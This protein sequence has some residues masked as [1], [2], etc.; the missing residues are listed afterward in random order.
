MCDHNQPGS[1]ADRFE[2]VA[3]IELVV[4]ANVDPFQDDA[5]AF[6]EEVPGNDVRVVLHDAEDDFISGLQVPRRPCV[7]HEVD[8]LGR[9][10][11]EQDLVTVAGAQKSP[12][13]RADAFV[14]FRCEVGQMVQPSVHIGVLVRVGMGYCVD[15]RLLFFAD[16]PLSR[17]TSGWPFTSRPRI[18]KSRRIVAT[19]N[20]W[21]NYS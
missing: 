19:L 7:R 17:Q 12:D 3:W 21:P 13:D 9:S 15:D 18:G 1:R 20:I 2:D 4:I 14:F 6:P 10:A 5:L 11:C 8:S 16:D